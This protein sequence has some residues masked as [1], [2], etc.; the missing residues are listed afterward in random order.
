MRP[1]S[2]SPP[3]NNAT[4]TPPAAS[5]S[6]LIKIAAAIAGSHPATRLRKIVRPSTLSSTWGSRLDRIWSSVLKRP[7]ISIKRAGRHAKV[8]AGSRYRD[9]EARDDIQ[10]KHHQQKEELG[11][12]IIAQQKEGDE[13][14]N[15]DGQRE[16]VIDHRY[17]LCAG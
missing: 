5:V 8:A 10:Q 16:P 11:R 3:A 1:D 15:K 9:H 13:R 4:A 2:C 7:W 17:C 12:S 14:R 6:I